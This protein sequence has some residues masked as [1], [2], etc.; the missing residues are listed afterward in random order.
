MDNNEFN[1]NNPSGLN[2][3]PSEFTT[4]VKVMAIAS[5]ACGV[6]AWPNICCCNLLG[7]VFGIAAIVLGIIVIKKV[8]I[9]NVWGI[10]S[11]VGISLSAIYIVV[12]L[13]VILINGA[14]AGLG[15]MSE[16]IDNLDI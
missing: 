10:L 7:I 5:I 6:L 1:Q 15:A 13:I 3:Y 11:I 8:S 14:T 2:E 12:V 16:I 9:K 4:A